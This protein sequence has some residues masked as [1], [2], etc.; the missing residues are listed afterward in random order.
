MIRLVLFQRTVTLCTA[1]ANML[2]IIYR[3]GATSVLKVL[4]LRLLND[5]SCATLEERADEPAQHLN[6]RYLGACESC[7]RLF[8]YDI[9]GCDPS[10]IQLQ[11]HLPGEQAHFLDGRYDRPVKSYGTNCSIRDHLKRI[12]SLQCH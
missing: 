3:T 9:H 5:L 10:V 6:G 8:E 7:W 2:Y 11:L 12:L 4:I 1:G